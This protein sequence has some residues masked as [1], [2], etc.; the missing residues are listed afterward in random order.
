[1]RDL[2]N[3]TDVVQSLNPAGNRTN[4]AQNGT[5]ADLRGYEAAE[6]VFEVGTVTD[7]THAPKIQESDD[8]SAWNDVAAGDQLGTLANLAATTPQ[9]VGYI[10][11][12][13]YVRAVVTGA[14]TTTGAMYSA[15]I[16]RGHKRHKGGPAV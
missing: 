15:T 13:R 12:K 16:T 6:I 5:S 2:H 7:G 10:G 3:N 14:G 8:N 9:R 11:G 1:M 4:G